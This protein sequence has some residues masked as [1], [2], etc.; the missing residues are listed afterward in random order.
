[1]VF[2]EW[3]RIGSVVV[4]VAVLVVICSAI[5]RVRR[6]RLLLRIPVIAIAIPIGLVGSLFLSLFVLSE[7]LG[8]ETDSTPIYSPSHKAAV[9]LED[10][11]AGATGGSTDVRVYEEHGLWVDTVLSGEWKFVQAED[12]RWL[13]DSHLLIRY[14]HYGDYNESKDCHST[15]DIQVQC[16]AKPAM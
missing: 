15:G 12:V 11:D 13:D 10:W 8:C 1:M 6:K 16:V 4:C 7:L 2:V 5:W 9:R 3:D 14:E